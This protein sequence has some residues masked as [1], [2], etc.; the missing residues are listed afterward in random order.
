MPIV[1]VKM[2]KG[3]PVTKKR[4]LA[5]AITDIVARELD[6]KPEWVTVLIEEYDRSNWATGG[7]L[8]SDKFGKGF[9]KK[10]SGK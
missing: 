6:V 8:H 5:K 1:T 7:Q 10:G 3:R 4:K 9:G 2:A